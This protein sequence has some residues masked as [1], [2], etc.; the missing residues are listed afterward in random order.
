M[1]MGR[2]VCESSNLRRLV[3]FLSLFIY[4]SCG[5]E[6]Y[7]FNFCKRFFL[8]IGSGLATFVVLWV[9]VLFSITFGSVFIFWWLTF[10]DIVLF[11]VVMM[12]LEPFFGD[13]GYAVNTYSYTIRSGLAVGFVTWIFLCYPSQALINYSAGL[14]YWWSGFSVLVERGNIEYFTQKCDSP[15]CLI[16]FWVSLL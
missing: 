5:P 7:V 2:I 3:C 1:C 9:A 4:A 13:F 12:T 10:A 15:D 8:V 6:G 16:S 11:L 14:G